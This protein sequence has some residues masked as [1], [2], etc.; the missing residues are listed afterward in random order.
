MASMAYRG[1]MGTPG[2]QTLKD[3]HN[4]MR[5]PLFLL[6]QERGAGPGAD[7]FYPYTKFHF[8]PQKE[9]NDRNLY[10]YIF[11]LWTIIMAKKYMT[12]QF[13]Y[14]WCILTLYC[15]QSSINKNHAAGIWLA[16][17]T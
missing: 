4:K 1:R 6:L 10:T 8:F 15:M 9:S 2:M 5:V 13:I 3:W 17:T 11:L 14:N 7:Q 16:C 12:L